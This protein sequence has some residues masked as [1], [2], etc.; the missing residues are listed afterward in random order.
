MRRNHFPALHPETGGLPIDAARA[1]AVS[2]MVELAAVTIG[3]AS[4]VIFRVHAIEA[5][6]A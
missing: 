5:Y 3:L 2:S 6:L 1:A 4:V